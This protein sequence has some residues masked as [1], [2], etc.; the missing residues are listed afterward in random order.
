MVNRTER[1]KKIIYEDKRYHWFYPLKHS[2]EELYKLD[3]EL[4]MQ[5]HGFKRFV[6]RS[7]LSKD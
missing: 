1:Q 2:L 3:M 7:L 4:D 6:H 5:N